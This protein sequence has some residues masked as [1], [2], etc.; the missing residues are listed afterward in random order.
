MIDNLRL[1]IR[2]IIAGVTHP[3]N[4]KNK[5]SNDSETEENPDSEEQQNQEVS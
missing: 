5:K 1:L 4:D 2:E 3:H